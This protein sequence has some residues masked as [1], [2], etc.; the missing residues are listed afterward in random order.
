MPENQ[1]DKKCFQ[2][3]EKVENA[4]EWKRVFEKKR[5]FFRPGDL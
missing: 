1:C 3:I 5:K 2:K 4:G